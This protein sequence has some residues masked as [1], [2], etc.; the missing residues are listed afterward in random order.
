M[1]EG[2]SIDDYRGEFWRQAKVASNDLHWLGSSGPTIR[3]SEWSTVI[4]F[5]S[6]TAPSAAKPIT[7]CLIELG[8]TIW[9]ADGRK[10][11][12]L[13]VVPVE[14]EDSPFVGFLK[15]ESA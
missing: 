15:V 5:S 8:E 3:R 2:P 12:V 11:R 13:D 6:S 7:R 1:S 14:E 9:T 10:L 4:A